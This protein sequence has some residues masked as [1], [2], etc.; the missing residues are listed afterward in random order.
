MAV[1]INEDYS[2]DESRKGMMEIFD[3]H[4]KDVTVINTILRIGRESHILIGSELARMQRMVQAE[5]EH[6]KKTQ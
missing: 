5:L 1:N 3:I 6:A 2:V 4:M